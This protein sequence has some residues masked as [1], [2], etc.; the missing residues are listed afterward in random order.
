MVAMKRILSITILSLMILLTVGCQP[1]EDQT[2]RD[3]ATTNEEVED[4]QEEIQLLKDK[5]V[6]LT[7]M[8]EDQTHQNAELKQS[9]EDI[10][11]KIIEFQSNISDEEIH[12]IYRTAVKI[13]FWF[14]I[15]TLAINPEESIIVDDQ[16]YFRVI[17]EITKYDGVD[18]KNF[19][20]VNKDITKYH[21]LTDMM[22]SVLDDMIVANLLS[23][24]LYIGVDG[25]LY[26]APADRG[27][28]WQKGA[29]TYEIIRKSDEK[30][31]YRVKVEI[32]S[33]G[34]TVS[35][36]ET[37]DFTLKPYEDGTWKFEEFSLVR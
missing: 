31:I 7:D 6:T 23:S 35:G 15:R 27:T 30:I 21:D 32:L 14:Q 11:Q 29:E 3:L 18:I 10:G 16:K 33:D 20:E 8:V 5:V 12:S 13:H 28:D 19:Y 34:K 36:Y 37:Y 26:G 22:E 24:N 9:V 4:L 1:E 2:Q 17:G 25:D